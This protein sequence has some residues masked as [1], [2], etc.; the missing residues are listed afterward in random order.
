MNENAK[1][2]TFDLQQALATT[3]AIMSKPPVAKTAIG[4]Y[5]C[6]FFDDFVRGEFTEVPFSPEDLL[7][8]HRLLFALPLLTSLL[9]KFP[10]SDA[11]ERL[12]AQ[13]DEARKDLFEA[14]QLRGIS[15]TGAASWC[16]RFTVV[17][18]EVLLDTVQR[19]S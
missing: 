19:L 6:Q 17:A 10:L 7:R 3:E 5:V 13:V 8:H 4:R 11:G 2:A 14:L 15:E 18:K 16:D 12:S 1:S 9:Q